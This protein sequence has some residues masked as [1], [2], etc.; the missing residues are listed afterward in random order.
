MGEM[1]SRRDFL[2]ALGIGA[3]VF[4]AGNLLDKSPSE[5]SPDEPKATEPTSE[6]LAQ[7]EKEAQEQAR[8]EREKALSPERIME[9]IHAYQEEFPDRLDKLKAMD[10]QRIPKLLARVIC[11]EDPYY[12]SVAGLIGVCVLNRWKNAHR[13]DISPTFWHVVMGDAKEFG[14][15]DAVR[16][17]FATDQ[18]PSEDKYEAHLLLADMLLQTGEFAY[19]YRKT[20]QN[21]AD[22]LSMQAKQARSGKT[23]ERLRKRAQEMLQSHLVDC[24]EKTFEPGDKIGAYLHERRELSGWRGISERFQ[25]LQ[26]MFLHI[27]AQRKNRADYLA[28]KALGETG[29]TYYRSPEEVMNKWE[30]ELG[31]KWINMPLDKAGIAGDP[32]EYVRFGVIVGQRDAEG[33]SE[34][35]FNACLEKNALLA[36]CFAPPTRRATV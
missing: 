6:E 19:L 29:M 31:V 22:G 30:T 10:N 36:E 13:G 35:E 34:E 28:K 25:F 2:K 17:Y 24:S 7:R 8:K 20:I 15:Q 14:R 26:T 9:A 18:D 3:G 12:I 32:H 1:P 11:S 16:K 27:I 5:P 23:A 4:A 33:L 21:H